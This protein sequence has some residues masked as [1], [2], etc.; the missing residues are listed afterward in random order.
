MATTRNFQDML[1]EFLPN[2]LL[3]EEMLKMDYFLQNVEKDE[4]WLGGAMVVPFKGAGA[5]SV[6]LGGLTA[7]NGIG[8]SK[9]ERGNITSQPEAWGSLIFDSRDLMEHGKVSEQNLLKLLPDEIE[10]MLQYMKTVVS[11]SWT[12]GSVFAKGL[13]DGTNTGLIT[14]DRPERFV[15]GQKV[16]LEDGNTSAAAFYV[17]TVNM[18]TGQLHLVTTRF[19]AVD[20]DI[21]AYDLADAP[22]FYFDGG[23]TSANRFSSIKDLLLSEANGGSANIYGVAKT[24]YPYT[25]AI[26]LSGTAITGTNILEKLFDSLL[27]LR[28]R[29]AG[30]ANKIFVSYKHWGSIMKALQA[31]KGAFRQASDVKASQYGWDEVDIA[32]PRGHATV[33]ALQEL[34]DDYI[35]ILDMSAFKIY[36]NGFFKKHQNPDGNEYFTVRNTTGYQYIVDTCFFGDMVLERPSRCGIIHSVPNYA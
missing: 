23:E 22:V 10:D 1:N 13:S 3:R 20:A 31:E 33:V 36:S 9:F 27:T 30:K 4:S 8:Q 14:V 35:P 32:G 18:E 24:K 25:Q 26:N 11:L 17:D 15:V 6:A 19:G 34:N 12:N 5:S 29:S 28:T 16:L 2:S 7:A 21:S